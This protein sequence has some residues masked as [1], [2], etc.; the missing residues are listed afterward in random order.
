MIYFDTTNSCYYYLYESCL[1]YLSA[2]TYDKAIDHLDEIKF[3]K[4]DN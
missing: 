1:L 4:T 3:Y 2:E